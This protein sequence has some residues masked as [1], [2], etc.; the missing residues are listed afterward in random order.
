MSDIFLTTKV[1]TVSQQHKGADRVVYKIL[2][3]SY[4]IGIGIGLNTI[5]VA[6]LV[7]RKPS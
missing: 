3:D 5:D 6:I 1:P 4:R 7:I 2:G